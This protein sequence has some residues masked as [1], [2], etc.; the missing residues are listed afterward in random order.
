[1]GPHQAVRQR[2]PLAPTRLEL[3]LWPPFAAWYYG[4]FFQLLSLR[5]AETLGL[6]N[7]MLNHAATVRTQIT[8]RWG[9]DLPEVSAESAEGI[10]LDLPDVGPRHYV[11]ND[12]VWRWYRGSAGGPYPCISA[13]LAVERFADQLI[14]RLGLPLKT[15]V[16][17]L[18][19]DCRNL[20]MPG[21][22]VGLLL[23]HFDKAADQLDAWLVHPQVWEMEFARTAGEGR[24]HVQG[25]DPEDV[26]GRERRK[27]TPR[28]AVAEMTVR[29]ML[30]QDQPRLDALADVADRL[31][32]NAHSAVQDAPELQ[33]RIV[34][35]QAW[36]SAFRPANYHLRRAPDGSV[37]V[38]HELPEPVATALA[39]SSA[40]VSAGNE[41]LRLELTYTRQEGDAENWP[42][43][44]LMADIALARQSDT[45][46]PSSA[47]LRLPNARVA[48]A[49][50]AVRSHARGS[51]VAADA[52]LRWAAETLLTAA[53][54]PYTDSFSSYAS[55]DPLAADRTAARATPSLLLA[56]FEH[57][58][59]D[60]NR[61]AQALTA[62]AASLF[63]EVRT[64]F[65]T[66]CAPLWAAPCTD[67]GEGCSPCLRHAPLWA[68]VEAGLGD[69]RLGPWDHQAQRRVPEYLP[70]PYPQT[71]PSVPV[72]AL[73]VNR[74]TMPTVCAAAAR[75]ADC[76][77]PQASALL[78][79][80]LDTHR[81][82][83]DHWM[84]EGYGGY[85]DAQRELVAR[86]LIDL[87]AHGEPEPLIAHLQTFAANAAAL[88]RL[89][90]DLAVV[91]TYD[92]QLRP[93]LPAVWQTVLQATCDALD[94]GA[95]LSENS[96]RPGEALAA[97]LPR[98]QLRISDPDPDNTLNRARDD[99]LAPE[100]LGGLVDRWITHAAGHPQAADAVA[101]FA[102]TAPK[103]WQCDTGLNWLERIINDH[104]NGFEDRWFITHWLGELRETTTMSPR[105]LS[106]WRRIIDSL[107]AAGDSRAV[108]LQRIDE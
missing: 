84:T 105:E 3:R 1:M 103:T 16:N 22:V 8:R 100:A 95:G 47:P 90:H 98:P 54:N 18:L 97:L 32:A 64:E 91:F 19:S 85:P 108:A 77:T 78:Q 33:D 81:R 9:E 50:A 39:P 24:M 37:I 76:L 57:L 27:V 36:A 48:V 87:T 61:T 51:I 106:Q 96:D 66:G 73:M 68:A 63:D 7:R 20:A 21:L 88:H 44:Q 82:G 62:L 60:K 75:S 99:W 79:V 86:V 83:M 69:C 10:E 72:G 89:L 70:P 11:G 52:D 58:G 30:A 102:R 26:I 43:E 14:D 71:L 92:A 67:D 25:P 41:A 107:A 34:V 17:L 40:A 101:Q 59:I 12:G 93:A 4:P 5:P 28:D 49:A 23:R 29:A 13:L 104:Y 55:I 74:L 15:V 80:L 6:I 38:Q 31:L 94:T 65:I 45:E 35:V 46:P 42:A 53:E 2:H 56:P